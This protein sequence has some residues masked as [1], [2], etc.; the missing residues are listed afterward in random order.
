MKI[1]TAILLLSV[2]FSAHAQLKWLFGKKKQATTNE[3]EQVINLTDGPALTVVLN[4]G[5]FVEL[6][7]VRSI[8]KSRTACFQGAKPTV[9]LSE[10]A[11]NLEQMRLALTKPDC[12]KGY[13]DALIAGEERKLGQT[14]ARWG[15]VQGLGKAV[16]GGIIS[17]IGI[18]RGADVAVA[19]LNALSNRPPTTQVEINPSDN[20]SVDI[21][22]NV[23]QDN[24]FTQANQELGGIPLN[25]VDS[26]PIAFAPGGGGTDPGE[27]PSLAEL[28]IGEGFD[29]V[30]E[31]NRCSDG[32][33]GTVVFDDEGGFT[34]I[35]E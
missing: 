23:G 30:V 11:Q 19:G 10:S 26:D 22:G 3:V 34:I 31:E 25:P 33:G 32:Q 4:G 14:Q 29:F 8:E 35:I 18:D 6:D 24:T 9:G 2:T 1:I 13:A 17:G 20:S 27:L 5:E 16:V 7:K 15:A 12:G 28:C 21:L